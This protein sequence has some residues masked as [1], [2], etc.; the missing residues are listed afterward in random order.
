MNQTKNVCDLAIAGRQSQVGRLAAWPSVRWLTEYAARQV[1]GEYASRAWFVPH[2]EEPV[3]CLNGAAADIE[4]KAEPR[5]ILAALLERDKH[6]VRRSGGQ[7][8]AVVFDLH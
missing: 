1:N 4:P 6:G 3:I 5:A 2:A 7:S 8:T